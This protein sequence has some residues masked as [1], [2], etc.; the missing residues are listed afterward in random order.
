MS[1]G[2]RMTVAGVTALTLAGCAG[3][4]LQDATKVKPSG[5]PFDVALYKEY[6]A[7]SKEE[8]AQGDYPDSD[9]FAR[10][11]EAAGS[12]RSPAPD[13]V[14]AR[15][16]FAGSVN[17]LT[18]FHSRLTAALDGNARVRNP[19]AAA[20]A[21]AQYEYLLEQWEENWSFQAAERDG[22]KKKFLECLGKI[23][24]KVAPN[25]VFFDFN[26]SDIT[27]DAMNTLRQIAQAAKAQPF[28]AITVTGHTDTVGSPGYNQALSERRAA[29][30][31][32]A[33]AGMTLPAS[34]ITTRGVGESQPL[35]A[36]GDGIAEP[37]NRR[38]EIVVQ[39]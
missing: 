23:E 16:V 4:E 32:S 26:R 34:Q 12:G 25:L 15:P 28:T 38:A 22:I 11:A 14:N 39:R 24:G 17:E 33:L 27:P 2:M 1:H 3:L 21:Q 18:S 13:P 37:Q 29:N 19:E 7:V 10:K 30:V 36:T 35:V 8:Y 31:K 6:I 20:C 9:F 5:T